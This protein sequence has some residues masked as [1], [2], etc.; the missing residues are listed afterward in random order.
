MEKVAV[1]GMGKSGVSC[2]N[3]LRKKGYHVS[4]FDQKGGEGIYSDSEPFAFD[5]FQLAV[6]SPGVPPSNFIVQELEKQGIPLLSEIELAFRFMPAHKQIVGITGTNGKTSVTS[7]IA[8]ALNFLGIKA[9]AAGNVGWPLTDALDADGVLVV[10]LSSFQLER[11][12]TPLLDVAV[13]LRITPDH[14]DRYPS[15]VEYAEAKV[16]I[17][18]LV[19]AGGSFVLHRETGRMFPHLQADKL[20]GWGEGT[21]NE[22]ATCAALSY[23]GKTNLE[24]RKALA[25]FRGPPH[26]IEWVREINGVHFF[27]DSKAT[28]VDSVL[29]ALKALRGP[30]HLIAGGKHKG[31]PYTPWKPFLE[32]KVEKMYLIGEAATQMAH[33]LSGSVSM[34]VCGDLDRAVQAVVKDV[35]PGAQVLLSPGCASFDQF[36]NYEER[37]N[38]FKQLV[39]ALHF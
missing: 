24:V 20:I 21:E 23:F 13:L 31:S 37:G 10:E 33:E 4:C 14:L 1:I 11:T 36:K 12:F 22:Q 6:I 32:E 18:N 19:K 38:R 2:T 16:R 8:H 29:F 5:G 26:R 35:K 9:A 17:G 39:C 30:I 7:M 15:F 3:L 28:N 27:N 34:Y 25:T